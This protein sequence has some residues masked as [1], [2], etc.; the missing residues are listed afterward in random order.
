MRE[1]FHIAGSPV[2]IG[3]VEKVLNEYLHT[4]NFT[5][6][7]ILCDI[8][9]YTNCWYRLRD[10]NWPKQPFVTTVD[11]GERSKTLTHCRRIWNALVD[12]RADRRSL[13]ISLGGG[14][15][16]DMGGFCAA[17]F[18]RG[19]SFGHVPTSLMGMT[20]ASIG[21]KHGVDYNELKNYLGI[22]ASPEFIIADAR[23]LD[24]L[25]NRE[26]RNGMAE[27]IKHAA[28]SDVRFLQSLGDVN[29]AIIED[30]EKMIRRSIE[31]KKY[32]VEGDERDKGKRASLNFGHTVGHAIES[33]MLKSATPLL[34]GEAI[35]L[36]M[37]V[38]GVISMHVTGL[39]NDEYEILKKVVKGQFGEV[40]LPGIAFEKLKELIVK[41]KK[42]RGNVVEF[43][44]LE[45]I[46]RPVVGVSVPDETI[47]DAWRSVEELNT[48]GG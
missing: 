6:Y 46:G 16:T 25:P 32:Y 2:Y 24:T 36:G 43:S 13:F 18:M 48:S 3:R 44:L 42:R 15:V 17:T 4:A 1:D 26:F 23:F 40:G 47:M 39:P 37:L 27:V 45:A 14:V 22:F 21:G 7:H 28:L 35:A 10:L 9:T 11:A 38:E 8:N 30:R 33:I 41:D 12:H 19:M 31:V 5:S 29:L 34:H 20:D